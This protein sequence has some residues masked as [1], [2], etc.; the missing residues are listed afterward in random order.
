M[1][2]EIVIGLLCLVALL[3]AIA[4]LRKVVTIF[5][6][7][8]GLEY[9]NGAFRKLLGPGSYFAFLPGRS[10]HVLDMRRTAFFLPGQEILTKDNVSIKITLA[11]FFEIGDPVKARHQSEN[12]Q[13]EL[14]TLAQ[15]ALRDLVGAVDIG[16]LLEKKVD[17]DAQLQSRVA[18]RASGLGLEVSALAVRDVMLPPNLKRAF[19]GVL[20]ARKEAQRK[21]EYARGEQAVLRSLANSSG[22]YEGNPSL[23]K[24]R[25]VQALAS[26]NNSIV[27]NADG[28]IQVKDRPAK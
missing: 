27:F 23:L 5:E 2:F 10:I 24:A 11:G 12:Y 18:E 1:R 13:T 14:Y 26:G 3:Y 6:F 4:R 8:R 7:Q 25:L 16:D 20:E 28:V 15:L 22:M 17:I 21:L 9:R 19:A